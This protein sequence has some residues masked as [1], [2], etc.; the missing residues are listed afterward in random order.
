M[1]NI[2]DNTIKGQSDTVFLSGTINN[3]I[4]VINNFIK[5]N[6]TETEYNKIKKDLQNIAGGYKGSFIASK[7]YT[8]E[9]VQSFLATLNEK[10]SNRKKKGVYYTPVDIVNFIL[11]NSFKLS[12][13][14]LKPDNINIRDLKE[15]PYSSLCYKKSIFDPTCGAGEFLLAA[16]ETKMN[17]LELHRVKVTKDKLI[18]VIETIKGNDLNKESTA[19]AK[20]R[21]YL[22]CLHRYGVEVSTGISE[23]LN[24][25][26]MNYD[27]VSNCS[28]NIAKYDIIVGNPPYVEDSKCGLALEKS[29]GNIYANVL[30]NAAHQLTK[31][32]VLGFVIPLSY[33]STPRM[34]KIRKTLDKCV[35]VQ[36]LLNYSDRPDS[37]FTAV[38][39][40]LS[41]LLA[42]KKEVPR[43]VY[44]S[45]YIYWYKEE[46]QD[47][48]NSVQV[49]ENNYVEDKFIPKLGTDFDSSIY[50]KII[51]NK[52]D[53]LSLFNSGS[54]SLYL[55][56]R[57]SFWIKAFLNKH[58]GSEY[59]E[60]KVSNANLKNYAMCLLN[61]S[62]FWWYWVVVSDCWHITQKELRGFKVPIVTSYDR[63]NKLAVSLETKLEKTKV[64]VGTKQ[65][66]YEYKHKLCINEIYAIDDYINKLFDLTREEG[67]YIKN[68]AYNY[69]VNRGIL[70]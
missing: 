44:S 59:K 13:E 17:L 66:E 38:H 6:Y 52:K 61:S 1:Q 34:K 8:Y 20:L 64:Y 27:Y 60:M 56:M 29:Y 32:G 26:F 69:R 23:V 42:Q 54:Y 65:T 39:Q 9:Q 41:I 47:L 25:S 70:R 62:L 3:A 35:P 40:K 7:L 63:L 46:R 33:V 51:N 12:S 50:F 48:F 30:D 36:Y 43:T 16:L 22:F 14:K 21:L 10:E 37:L 2:K 57:A 55:N 67:S 24:K 53:L 58:T 5:Q 15:L 49:V 28:E 68:F 11:L 31:D 45:N 18:N 19:I 4:S